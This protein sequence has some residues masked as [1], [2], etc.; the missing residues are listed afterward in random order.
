MSSYKNKKRILLPQS[1]HFDAVIAQSGGA[2][3]N[4]KPC[5]RCRVSAR[6]LSWRSRG[7]CWRPPRRQHHSVIAVVVC[8]AGA[9][10]VQGQAPRCCAADDAATFDRPRTQN[11]PFHARVARPRRP[12]TSVPPR[13]CVARARARARATA[14]RPVRVRVRAFGVRCSRGH[15]R[16]IVSTRSFPSDDARGALAS[17]GRNRSSGSSCVHAG[18]ARNEQQQ[19]NSRP[20]ANT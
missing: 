10:G 4:A 3:A 18:S 19:R 8:A 13:E 14:E 6:C 17:R 16:K 5:L 15:R 11:P 7:L 1:L 20:A 9:V 2:E 12:P